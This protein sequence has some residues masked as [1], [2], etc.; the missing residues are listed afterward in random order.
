MSGSFVDSGLIYAR[1]I[2]VGADNYVAKI[3]NE[4]KYVKKVN[5]EIMKALNSI[6]RFASV[7][8]LPLG[9]ALFY[10]SVHVAYEQDGASMTFLAWAF[11][12]LSLIHISCSRPTLSQ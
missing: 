11:S 8:M 9:I 1:V 3:N 12:G 6:V 2:H 7:I 5:S 4:A 10:S